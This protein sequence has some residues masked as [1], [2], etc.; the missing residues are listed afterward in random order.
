MAQ[1]FGRFPVREAAVEGL[2]YGLRAWSEDIYA[3][4][5]VVATAAT[6]TTDAHARADDDGDDGDLMITPTA[7]S[8]KEQPAETEGEAG[9]CLIVSSSGMRGVP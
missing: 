7:K 4:S 1:S 5:A 3:S 6:A 8:L 9:L 2:S